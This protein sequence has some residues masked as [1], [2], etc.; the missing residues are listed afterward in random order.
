MVGVVQLQLRFLGARSLIQH[1]VHVLR[2]A[3]KTD[4]IFSRSRSCRGVVAFACAAHWRPD[5][6][7]MIGACSTDR[8]FWGGKCLTANCVIIIAEDV[9]VSSVSCYVDVSVSMDVHPVSGM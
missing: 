7:S 3:T 5:L 1:V 9:I 4:L 2:C 8:K 6:T